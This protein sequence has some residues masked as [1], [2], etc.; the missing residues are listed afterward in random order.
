MNEV[1]A[2]FILEVRKIWGSERLCDLPEAIQCVRGKAW[3]SDPVILKLLAP[4]YTVMSILVFRP[5]ATRQCG[6]RYGCGT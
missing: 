3:V 4:P 6:D 5:L 2:I 1:G